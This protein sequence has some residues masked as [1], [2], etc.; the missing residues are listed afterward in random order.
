MVLGFPPQQCKY[1]QWDGALGREEA[2]LC[3]SGIVYFCLGIAED[4]KR[5]E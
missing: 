2:E 1:L 3:V 4:D 5:E